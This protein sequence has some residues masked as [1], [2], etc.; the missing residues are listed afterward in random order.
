MDFTGA[1]PNVDLSGIDSEAL[2]QAA[3]LSNRSAKE[4]RSSPTR[5]RTPR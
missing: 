3:E 1:D 2:R 4:S 5:L